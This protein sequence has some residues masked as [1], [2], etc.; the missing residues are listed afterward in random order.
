ML[1]C[2]CVPWEVKGLTIY[3]IRLIHVSIGLI[4]VS[5]Y[6]RALDNQGILLFSS[7]F[8]GRAIFSYIKDF[9]SLKSCFLLLKNNDFI[10]LVT[11]TVHVTPDVFIIN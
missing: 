8:W 7:E 11:Y 4:H 9:L 3:C 6:M 1:N 2:C 10:F 5:I